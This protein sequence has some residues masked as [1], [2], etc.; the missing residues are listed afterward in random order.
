MIYIIGYLYSISAMQKKIQKFE[1]ALNYQ[2]K[3]YISR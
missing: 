2:N 1:N 3:K